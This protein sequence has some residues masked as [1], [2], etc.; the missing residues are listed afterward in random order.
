[1]E[2][3]D[4]SISRASAETC[5]ETSENTESKEENENNVGSLT[6]NF[7]A[8]VFKKPILVGP[9]RGKI[10]GHVKHNFIVKQERENKLKEDTTSEVFLKP[11]IDYPKC[12]VENIPKKDTDSENSKSSE[13][14]KS[15]ILSPSEHLKEKHLPLPYKEPKWSGVPTIPYSIEILKSGKIVDTI[16]LDL[17]PF[18]VFGRLLTCDIHLA[19]PTISRYHAILQYRKEATSEDAPGFYIYDLGS[20]H[21]TF[22]NK[23]RIKPNIYVR[24]QVGHVL[25]L[26]GSTRL[27]I[28][29]G[30]EDDMEPE[31]ELS[32]SQ[33][34]LKRQLQLQSRQPL[35]EEPA[36][37]NGVD[38]GIGTE[39]HLVS[40]EDADEETDLSENPFAST[41]NEELFI[42]DPKKS[43][44]G[45]FERE[46]Y[47]LEYNVEEK[48]FGQFVCR[49]EIPIDAA[50]SGTMTAEVIHKG[51]KKEAVVQCA[52][53]ACRIL[54]RYGLL[55]QATHVQSQGDIDGQTQVSRVLWVGAGKG[56]EGENIGGL[57]GDYGVQMVAL[58]A[59]GGNSSGVGT[60][61]DSGFDVLAV[62]GG[63]SGGVL[64]GRLQ[65]LLSVG[66]IAH[67]VRSPRKTQG[68]TKRTNGWEV[69]RRS[70]GGMGRGP[71]NMSCN[72]TGEGPGN[73][74]RSGMRGESRRR[75]AK[76]WEEDDFYDS[77]EDTY[78]DRTG[79]VE[80]KRQRRMK[81]A[82][83]VTSETETYD[84]L[85]KKY[86]VVLAEIKA[87]ESK[88]TALKKPAKL[89]AE[90]IDDDDDSDPL[91][92]Y[93][94]D[95]SS[96]IQD[97]KKLK[98]Q[99]EG[100][101][102]EEQ[103]LYT[104]IKIATPASFPNQSIQK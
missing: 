68:R 32:V 12:V 73:V 37:D 81:A 36:D 77:D 10:A 79:N 65:G 70:R 24:L 38:W 21:G 82:G 59:Q 55:R 85:T 88:L 26:G 67:P 25:K 18:Y 63:P 58:G 91:D 27:L 90:N 84:T 13:Y 34:V 76:N 87:V 1:M 30:P 50:P 40:R 103:R 53:E 16:N 2:E 14:E 80:N 56:D 71:G 47:D 22:L 7:A 69:G 19:H 31:S 39:S 101:K 6:Q 64:L 54:D 104:L 96:G 99:L 48:G 41:N 78:F 92:K 20:T 57:G 51:K 98:V 46:G 35:N 8:S 62:E 45:W 3:P 4:I 11:L 72:G 42:D 93:I 61:G 83:K 75:K 9:R 15:N 52:L 66:T 17:K 95:I 102:T 23:Y 44:R 74:S 33:L 43:L 60:F 49:I 29:Q 100:L 5:E 89:Q 97:E 28:L 94:N 86:D